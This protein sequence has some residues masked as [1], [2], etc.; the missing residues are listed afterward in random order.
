[1]TTALVT[2]NVWLWVRLFGGA[3]D[4]PLLRSEI[5]LA[6]TSTLVAV[7]ATYM[8]WR[9]P[10]RRS[11]RMMT[12]PALAQSLATHQAGHIVAAYVTEGPSITAAGL[13]TPCKTGSLP[14]TA[15]T[16]SSMRTELTR[17]LAGIAAEEIFTGESGSHAAAD[18]AWAT[19]LAANMVGRYGMSGSLVSL[20]PASRRQRRF[21]QSVLEDARARKELEAVLREAKRDATRLMLENRHIIIELRAALLRD[22]R[23]S[24]AQIDDCV[25][26]ADALRHSEDAVLVDLRTAGP[27]PVVKA[28]EL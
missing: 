13:S 12:T 9:N 15:L 7:G 3:G 17:A 21:I 18:L 11:A 2:I 19:E 23:L 26:E 10:L 1:L 20:T 22:Q 4:G 27:R 16:E 6:L 25:A 14:T 28:S 24:A 8:L 5:G